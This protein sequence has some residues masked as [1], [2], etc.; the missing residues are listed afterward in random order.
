M[1][2]MGFGMQKWIYGM[3][4]RKPF[5]MQRKSSFTPV[6][7]YSRKFNLQP[8][9][10]R[11]GYN[12]G[13]VLFFVIKLVIAFAIPEYLDQA[14]LRHKQNLSLVVAKDNSAFNFL[15]TSGKRRLVSGEISDAY[16]E[17]KLALA[18]KPDDKELN[19][20]LSET[21]GILC[22]DCSKNCDDLNALKF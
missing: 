2:F 16:S 7:V 14:R 21:L 5:S 17:F 12:F 10:D 6:P 3:R 4:P 18:I 20:L 19:R 15:M 22:F 1:G 9:K 13:F 8:S 11:G